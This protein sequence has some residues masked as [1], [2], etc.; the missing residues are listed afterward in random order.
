M[1]GK[2]MAKIMSVDNDPNITTMV[3]KILEAEGY[4]VSTAMGGGECLE[5]LKKGKPD[6]LL[7]DAMMPDLSGWDVYWRIRKKDEKLKVVFV[8]VMEVSPGRKK[9]L[10][11]D[12]GISDYVIKPFTR[13]E[14]VS[15]VKKVL[16]E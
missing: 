1:R 10:I 16:G 14:I 2:N 6:L 9:E 13:E 11:R 4:E 8:S 7:L 15:V 3:K 12:Y 5:M